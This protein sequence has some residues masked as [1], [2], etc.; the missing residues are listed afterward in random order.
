[1]QPK[2]TILNLKIPVALA[3]YAMTERKKVNTYETNRFVKNI[4]CYLVLKSI[5]PYSVIRSW[6]NQIDELS[7]YC[8]CERQTFKRR[9][10]WCIDMGLIQVT[11]N[12]LR[13]VS[14][15][16]AGNIFYC[17]LDAYNTIQYNPETNANIHLALFQTEIK[18]NKQRQLYTIQ[19]KLCKNPMLK[20]QIKQTLLRHG[21]DPVKLGRFD[22]FHNAM[23][24]LYS[25]AF[26]SEPETHALLI[27]VRPDCNRSVK[28]LQRSWD[29]KHPQLVS[30]YKRKLQGSG[31]IVIHKGSVIESRTRARNE[32]SHVIWNKHSKQT[33]L[34]MVDVL[35]L[36]NVAP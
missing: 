1:M 21:A 8:Q 13:L 30:Y 23:R 17:K 6:K 31:L 26:I 36:K 27:Q 7:Y 11:G 14:W 29:F 20:D 24:L 15:K 34:R 22:Y 16:V 28:G 19:K 3:R 12:D 5:T 18:D 32:H 25:K 9:L 2:H 10:Q 4:M 33:A 35:E